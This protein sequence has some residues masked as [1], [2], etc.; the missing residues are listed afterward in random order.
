MKSVSRRCFLMT[1]GAMPIVMLADDPA[2][3]WPSMTVSQAMRYLCEEVFP[4]EGEKSHE[5][6]LA[7]ISHDTA[8]SRRQDLAKQ[9]GSRFNDVCLSSRSRP[10]CRVT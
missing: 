10:G 7:A 3:L 4:T 1:V 6:D 5:A 9:E 2:L 8:G